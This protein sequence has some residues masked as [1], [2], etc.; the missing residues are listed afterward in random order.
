MGEFFVS[1]SG[2]TNFL[3]YPTGTDAGSLLR[4]ATAANVKHPYSPREILIR[5]SSEGASTTQDWKKAAGLDF[6]PAE[7]SLS[8]KTGIEPIREGAPV[9]VISAFGS[10]PST[11]FGLTAR[12]L[13]GLGAGVESS[14]SDGGAGATAGG[15]AAADGG[16][17]DADS[18]SKATKAKRIRERMREG[19]Q[20]LGAKLAAGSISEHEHKVLLQRMQ[21]AIALDNE[22]AAGEDGSQ[23]EKDKLN[24]SG[25]V[26]NLQSLIRRNTIEDFDESMEGSSNSSE[27]SEYEY[28]EQADDDDEL[29]DWQ[30]SKWRNRVKKAKGKK[31]KG[32]TKDKN[33]RSKE[34]KKKREAK[35]KW[36]DGSDGGSSHGGTQGVGTYFYLSPEAECGTSY[37]GKRCAV[38]CSCTSCAPPDIF[39]LT[40][41]TSLSLPPPA[42]VIFTRAVSFSL[43][44]GTH[45]RPRW[46]GAKC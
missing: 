23:E 37:D 32:K 41:F 3:L 36:A 34:D 10:P 38:A 35:A 14:T 11:I 4:T 33:K 39:R 20:L 1:A 13:F 24:L 12:T 44:C 28:D 45:S 26:L 43:R 7:V 46:S 40:Y 15:A 5:A 30:T 6:Q 8:V 21:E 18:N 29:G 17:A 42:A 31:A 27:E 25:S 22:A 2:L 16:A 19:K 9:P